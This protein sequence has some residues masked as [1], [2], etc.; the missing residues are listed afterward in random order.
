MVNAV[1]GNVI[2]YVYPEVPLTV[3]EAA[4][5]VPAVVGNVTPPV[6]VRVPAGASTT[7]P[8]VVDCTATLPKFISTSL[9]ILI[10]VTMVA[11][12]VADA[13]SCPWTVVARHANV[14]EAT[15]IMGNLFILSLFRC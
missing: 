1:V 3:K 6:A 2:V 8:A 9:T 11:V 12:A 7:V 5:T 10:G 14:N 15:K 13:V 4:V